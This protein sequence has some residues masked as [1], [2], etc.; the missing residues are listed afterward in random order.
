MEEDVMKIKKITFNQL[1]KLNEK[2]E[3]FEYDLIKVLK[4]MNKGS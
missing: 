1:K 2:E 3:N 4:M